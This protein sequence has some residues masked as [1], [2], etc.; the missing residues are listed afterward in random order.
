ME[1][2]AEKVE[3]SVIPSELVEEPALFSID[4]DEKPSPSTTAIVLNNHQIDSVPITDVL[5]IKIEG[6]AVAVTRNADTED[7]SLDDF[8]D[9]HQ[10]AAEENGTPVN[11]TESKYLE[12]QAN[13]KRLLEEAESRTRNLQ[14]Y[15]VQKD[16]VIAKLEKDRQLLEKEKMILRKENELSTREK[17]SAVIK[18]AT[19]EKKALD[20]KIAVDQAEKRSKDGAREIELMSGKVKSLINDKT[21]ICGLLDAKGHELKASQKEVEKWKTDL[22]Q[23]EMKAKWN[24]VKLKQEIDAKMAAEK[25]V[26]E[27]TAELSSVAHRADDK[28]QMSEEQMMEN[29]ANLILLKHGNEVKEKL[30][31]TLEAKVTSLT[32]E[33]AETA[34]NLSETVTER[35]LLNEEALRWQDENHEL[36][37]TL[38]REVMKVADLQTKVNDLETLRTQYSIE[39]ETTQRLHLELEALQQNYDDQSTEMATYRAKETELLQFN[40]EL[41][42]RAVKLQNEISLYN[43]KS[44]ALCLENEN[45]KRD[46]KFYED[47][48]SELESQLK[49]E[50]QQRTDERNLLTKHISE[51]TKLHEGAQKKLENSLGDID[52]IKKKHSQTVKELNRELAQLR[53][54]S[55]TG[56]ISSRKSSLDNTEENG[57]SMTVVQQQQPQPINDTDSSSQNESNTEVPQIQIKEPSKKNLIDRIVRLQ[58][59]SARQ[60]EK[61]DYLENHS[62]TLS[63]ELQKKHKLIQYYM[64]RDQTGALASSKSDRN[65]AQLAKYGGVMSAIYSGIKSSQNTDMT[66]DLSLEINRK[67]QA[68]LEDTLLKNITLKENLDTLGLEIDKLTRRQAGAPQNNNGGLSSTSSS[69]GGGASLTNPKTNP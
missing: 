63:A 38:D 57:Q 31:E 45:I 7:V 10:V 47:Q 15:L 23:L 22:A 36:Q 21:R 2:V 28:N 16:E 35:D 65:K 20:M 24:L 29:Q 62:A 8:S 61:I 3:L 55:D 6:S 43:S 46:K 67:L 49:A 9:G 59:A 12:E 66:L 64:L 69:S 48:I 53:K 68:V 58:H 11:D 30:V 1:G 56:S 4:D 25:R 41:T 34:K 60:T 18:Y 40:Q 19:V 17:E 32:A 51:R 44:V 14:L 37:N 33:L 13:L 27:L 26:E 52:A 42:E 5:E 54:K 39:R 50:K